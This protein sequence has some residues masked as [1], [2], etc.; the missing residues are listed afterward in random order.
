MFSCAISPSYGTVF[1]DDNRSVTKLAA[2]T[3]VYK[4]YLNKEFIVF[5][6]MVQLAHDNLH[7]GY[8]VGGSWIIRAVIKA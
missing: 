6:C 2:M 5:V 3:T 7:H 1:V 8:S 4:F